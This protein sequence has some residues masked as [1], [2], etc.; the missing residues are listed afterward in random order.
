MNTSESQDHDKVTTL[1]LMD[2][3]FI[4]LLTHLHTIWI[5]QSEIFFPDLLKNKKPKLQQQKSKRITHMNQQLPSY[6][7]TP[8][9]IQILEIFKK[10][11]DCIF[12]NTFIKYLKVLQSLGKFWKMGG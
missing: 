2:F 6:S 10:V 3:F 11:I 4:V 1:L 5:L 7:Y 12:V 9:Y 8:K